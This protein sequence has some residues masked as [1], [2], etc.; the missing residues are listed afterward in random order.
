MKNAIIIFLLLLPLFCF[1][2]D[3]KFSSETGFA[4]V[5]G[6][7]LYYEVAGSG[8]SILFVHGNFGDCRHWDHQFEQLS[9]KFKVIRFDVRGYGKSA[10]P[11]PEEV[12]YDYEDIKSLMDYLKVDR[13]HVCGLSMGSGIATDFA[14]MY[15]YRCHSLIPIGP[16]PSGYGEGE[17][18][19]EGT[20]ML[21]AVFGDVVKTLNEK[22]PKEATD[23][24][25]TGTDFVKSSVRS[26]KALNELLKMGYDYD[27]WGFKNPNKRS[28][29]SP[30]A[31]NRLKE[32]KVPTLIV[33]AE[34]DMA[35]CITVADLMEK[36]IKGSNKISLKDAG[37]CMNMDKP[38]E[39]NAE[40]VS[41]IESLK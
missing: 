28:Y 2:Q 9:R 8:E 7:K 40:L 36:E 32:I 3:E 22:G 37:H 39:F 31:I 26:D 11:D 18:S 38:E 35:P 13:A 10:N 23:Y 20:N 6:T 27:Y 19:N 21:W 25:W 14:L 34:F 41:F 17:F 33:T 4:E 1:C 12:Y 5:N 24:W 16:W 29:P 15:P 30:S